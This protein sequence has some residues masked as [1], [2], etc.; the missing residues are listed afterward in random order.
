MVR[1]NLSIVIRRTAMA[2]MN[3][4]I[5]IR[6]NSRGSDEDVHCYKKEQPSFG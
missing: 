6:R 4:S 1:M 2:Q 3:L 5:V